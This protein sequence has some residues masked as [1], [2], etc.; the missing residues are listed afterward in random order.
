M[1]GLPMTAVIVRGSANVNA[2]A[3]TRAASFFHGVFLLISLLFIPGIINLIPLASLA[4]VLLV[5]G[6]KLTKVS[7]FKDMYK[8]GWDQLIPFVVTIIA[9]VFTDLLKGIAIGMAV[10]VFIILRRNAR[11]YFFKVEEYKEDKPIE[12]IL[13]DEVS[14]LNKASIQ[15]TLDHLPRNSHVIINGTRSAYIDYDVLEILHNFK[16]NAHYKNIKV[17]LKGIK[18]VYKVQAH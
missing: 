4:A 7:L 1:G 5:V 10:G 18:E 14:F 6:Y 11:N 12:I 9:I 8:A 3:K 13:A 17:E 2:G 15:L 16:E